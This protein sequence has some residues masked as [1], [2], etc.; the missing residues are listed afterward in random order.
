MN[1]KRRFSNR[2]ALTLPNAK[3]GINS[4]FFFVFVVVKESNNFVEKCEVAWK[5]SNS[6][7]HVKPFG[8][9]F[10][11]THLHTVSASY[12][13]PSPNA[14]AAIRFSAFARLT[15]GVYRLTP[16]SFYDDHTHTHDE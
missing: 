8:P 1:P 11:S 5:R 9:C 14:N 2:D 6:R 12:T 4:V 16:H 3:N 10:C 7:K 13:Q 15:N